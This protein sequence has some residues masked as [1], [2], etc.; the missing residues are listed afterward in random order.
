MRWKPAGS[1]STTNAAERVDLSP[2]KT[3]MYAPLAKEASDEFVR[4][5]LHAAGFIASAV[6]PVLERD[7]IPVDVTQALIGN[8]DAMGITAEVI[9]DLLGSAKGRLGVD[10][11]VKVRQFAQ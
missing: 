11:P 4:T 3:A 7:A 9:D 10:D 2:D 5:Q 6:I 1:V 8:G